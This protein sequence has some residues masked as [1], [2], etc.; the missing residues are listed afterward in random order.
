M[1]TA[2]PMSL[3]SPRSYSS[4]DGGGS[5]H[6]DV[7]P[8]AVPP[9]QSQH[10]SPA[11]VD[12]SEFARQSV[13]P[14]TSQTS[15]GFSLDSLAWE[16]PAIPIGGRAAPEKLKSSVPAQRPPRQPTFR[17][18]TVLDVM[19]PPP[20]LPHIQAG[21]PLAPLVDELRAWVASSLDLYEARDKQRQE[22]CQQCIAAAH[23]QAVV[24]AKRLGNEL[25]TMAAELDATKAALRDS[26]SDV[27]R[28]T[29][30]L[31][32]SE[33]STA[34]AVRQAVEEKELEV[35][36]ASQARVDVLEAQVWHPLVVDS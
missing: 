31:H 22:L 9:P 20:K 13:S 4:P 24:A 26:Q 15:S 3:I 12:L 5:R 14:V 29:H 6:E 1:R 2:S 7:L 23:R 17:P 32:A 27:L 35:V 10:S 25:Q 18:A 19:G 30:Q 21:H 16:I 33:A 34:T 36:Q 8:V 28:L 11:A